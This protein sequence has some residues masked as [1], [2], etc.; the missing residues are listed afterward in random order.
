[1]GDF[2]LF[3]EI[4]SAAKGSDKEINN[5]G[6]LGVAPGT[7][8]I[9]IAWMY[10]DVLNMH[11]SRGDAMALMHF[12]NLMKIPCTIRR[13]NMLSEPVPFDWADMLFFPSGDI[14]S[15]EDICK[16][17]A[18]QRNDFKKY[19]SEGRII[20]AIGSTGVILAQST[21]YLDGRK[22]RGLGLLGMKMKQRKTVHGD[23]LWIKL[24]DGKELL[25]T[26]IQLADVKLTSEQQPL[27]A[28]IYG[29]GN[30]GKGQE[31]A[32]T[33]NVIY[34]H[35]LGPLLAK[36][37]QF[38]AELLKTAASIAGMETEGLIL[39]DSDISLENAALEDHKEFITSKVEKSR[40]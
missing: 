4:R 9:R 5:H 17:L 13:V 23:D 35:L 33:G 20:L 34:T 30:L 6:A 14:S 25:G 3:N 11:G 27:G 38:T 21:A 40:K 1:M 22:V 7:R 16:T 39:K 2:K 37:P 8:G 24:P 31:G 15:M 32:R 12:S 18:P 26:Q 29:R 19:V 28:T 10:P 36:N